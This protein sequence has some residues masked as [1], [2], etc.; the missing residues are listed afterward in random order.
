MNQT[1]EIS[2]YKKKI[3]YDK[4]KKNSHRCYMEGL[5]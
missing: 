1:D 2:N 4:I 3:N 5:S